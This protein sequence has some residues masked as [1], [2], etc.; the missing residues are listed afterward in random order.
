MGTIRIML[1]AWGPCPS[2]PS[3]ETEGLEFQEELSR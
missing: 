1:A 3:H 2:G